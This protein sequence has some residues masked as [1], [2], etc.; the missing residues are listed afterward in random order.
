MISYLPLMIFEHT[1]YQSYLHAELVERNAKNPR[2]SLRAM[3]KQIDVS[4]STLSEIMKNKRQLSYKRAMVIAEKLGLSNREAEYFCTLVQKEAAYTAPM[5]ERFH[6]K[7]TQLNPKYKVKDLSIDHFR[8]ISEWH[9]LAIIPL[10]DVKNFRFTAF[11]ISKT[12][13]IS[14]FEAQ[15]AIERLLRLELIVKDKSGQFHR[16]EDFLAEA[17]V[18]EESLRKFHQQTL[19][20]AIESLKTQSPQEKL[21][22]TEQFAIDPILL[23]KADEIVEE[24]VEKLVKLFAKSKNKTDVYHLGIQLFNLTNKRSSYE[25]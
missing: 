12:L 20:K 21:M 2:Y 9:H 17:K 14:T 24:C 11:Q 25:K 15:S 18:P 5:A 16:G 3:A 13:G 22:R 19:E 8:A 23:P 4:P 6:D 10:V 7:L 1:T